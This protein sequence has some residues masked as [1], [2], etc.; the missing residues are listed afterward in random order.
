VF[1]ETLIAS[2]EGI[3]AKNAFVYGSIKHPTRNFFVLHKKDIGDVTFPTTEADPSQIERQEWMGKDE[4][5]A[6]TELDNKAND[7]ASEVEEQLLEMI[8]GFSK[9]E[10]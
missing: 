7:P 8:L 5:D 2:S 6:I 1:A 9:Q 4:D 3:V 10:K